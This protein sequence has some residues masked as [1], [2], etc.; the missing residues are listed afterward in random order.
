MKTVC[1]RQVIYP[2]KFWDTF[3]FQASA[4]FPFIAFGVKL[5]TD[6]E[7][8]LLCVLFLR[9]H[10]YNAP[11]QTSLC[12][13]MCT[14]EYK[15]HAPA[16]WKLSSETKYMNSLCIFQNLNL[17]KY[18]LSHFFFCSWTSQLNALTGFEIIFF[19]ASPFSSSYFP[20]TVVALWQEITTRGSRIL[21]Y[22]RR[23]TLVSA[24]SCVSTPLYLLLSFTP[25]FPRLRVSHLSNSCNCSSLTHTFI[26]SF[27]HSFIRSFIS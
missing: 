16:T 1:Y 27:I 4:Y 26:H 25:L 14:T 15:S 9:I 8:A 7:Q 6:I 20:W 3:V 5:N 21:A 18:V 2:P 12:Y 11:S 23:L 13:G 19:V 17:E 10:Y 24:I 22:R